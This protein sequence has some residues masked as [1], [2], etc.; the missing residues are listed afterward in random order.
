MTHRAHRT[1]LVALA[2]ATLIVTALAGCGE[3]DPEVGPD[4]VEVPPFEAPTAGDAGAD[5]DIGPPCEVVDSDPGTPVTFIEVQTRVFG[6]FCN[7][8]T[9]PGLTG[10]TVGGLDLRTLETA[11]AGGRTGG[12]R[13]IVP[14]DACAS[15]IVGK[16]TGMPAFGQRMPRGRPP[17]TADDQQLIIDWIAEGARP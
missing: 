17:L 6:Q 3:L 15:F 5:A 4:R 9:T 7:C 14:G 10:I 12:A 8:H 1:A 13:D 16:V 2:F 11:L